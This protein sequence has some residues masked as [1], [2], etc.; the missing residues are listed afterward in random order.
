VA[1]N[2]NLEIE[3]TPQK[4]KGLQQLS[5][6]VFL[7]S[8]THFYQS[9]D[10]TNTQTTIES[11]PSAAEIKGVDG[12]FEFMGQRNMKLKQYVY[13]CLLSGLQ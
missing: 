10:E 6:D 1:T 11:T 13:A 9:R 5:A 4:C 12:S 2:Q 8:S 7:A 3:Q